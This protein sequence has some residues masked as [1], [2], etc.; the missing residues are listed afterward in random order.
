MKSTIKDMSLDFNKEI[1]QK[2]DSQIDI[3]IKKEHI[4]QLKG[5]NLNSCRA[6]MISNRLFK[7]HIK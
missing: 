1:K 2:L 4:N 7:I 3:N 6:D 5:Y